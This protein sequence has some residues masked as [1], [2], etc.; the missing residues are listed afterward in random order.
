MSKIIGWTAW[1]YDAI[2]HEQLT[3]D[4]YE[5][6][7]AAVSAGREIM[8][9]ILEFGSDTPTQNMYDNVYTRPVY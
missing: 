9:R 4:V 1:T 2:Y 7:V 5:T 8:G 3:D 6:A